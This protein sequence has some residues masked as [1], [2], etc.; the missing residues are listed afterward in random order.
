MS[1]NFK[2]LNHIKVELK[3]NGYLLNT[4]VNKTGSIYIFKSK[5]ELGAD[6]EYI[7]VTYFKTIVAVYD[8]CYDET[9]IKKLA[10]TLNKLVNIVSND[11]R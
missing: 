8:N 5:K 2:V 7:V 9:D 6:I 3:R 1:V 10:Y 4:L 11:C